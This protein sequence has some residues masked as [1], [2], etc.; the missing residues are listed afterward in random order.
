MAM[1]MALIVRADESV[2]DK[3]QSNPDDKDRPLPPPCD[4]EN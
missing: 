1:A 2:T 4:E 3:M